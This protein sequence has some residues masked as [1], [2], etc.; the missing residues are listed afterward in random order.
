[1]IFRTLSKEEYERLTPEQKADYLARLMADIR[2]KAAEV[3]R[4]IDAR[5]AGPKS[6]E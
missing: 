3:Q 5:N 4:A 2:Q 1:M 6:S